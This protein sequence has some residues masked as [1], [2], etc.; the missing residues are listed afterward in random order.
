MEKA[1]R[2]QHLGQRENARAVS[3]LP[4]GRPLLRSRLKLKSVP[5]YT[6]GTTIARVLFATR[7][8]IRQESCEPL[9]KPPVSCG[10]GQA[11]FSSRC[12]RLCALQIIC[13]Q[14]VETGVAVGGRKAAASA[15]QR[16]AMFGTPESTAAQECDG[17]SRTL[18]PASSTMQLPPGFARLSTKRKL[19]AHGTVE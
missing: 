11:S 17:L 15:K 5:H 6:S 9:M 1:P 8:V 2:L 13:K 16:L 3:S 19:E 7:D 12:D 14:A 18:L 10:P 4:A